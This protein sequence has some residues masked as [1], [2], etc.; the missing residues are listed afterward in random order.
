MKHPDPETSEKPKRRQFKAAYK[1][2]IL[3]ETD[4]AEGGP[5]RGHHAP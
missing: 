2:K 1:L 5:D 3:R 4:E